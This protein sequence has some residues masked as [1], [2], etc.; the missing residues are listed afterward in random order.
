MN[1]K[2]EVEK[3]RESTRKIVQYLGYMDNMFSHIGSVSQCYALQRI[4]K[5]PMTILELSQEL[6]LDHSSVSRLAK[7]LVLKGYRHRVDNTNDRRSW[8][9]SLTKLGKEKVQEIHKIAS[10]QAE[11]ALSRLTDVQK[12]TVVEGMCLYAEALK[13][14][15]SERIENNGNGNGKT[16]QDQKDMREF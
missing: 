14:N 5:K 2:S 6:A 16:K 15:Y 4:E 1:V 11:S 8:Y 13:N 7:I 9:M 3:I 10:A 12:K